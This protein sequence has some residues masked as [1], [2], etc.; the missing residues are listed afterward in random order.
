MAEFKPIKVV[1]QMFRED[2]NQKS[3][4]W[5]PEEIHFEGKLIVESL[6]GFEP[7]GHNIHFALYLTKDNRYTLVDVYRQWIDYRV[8]CRFFDSLEDI[9][10]NYDF[11]CFIT[12]G[13]RNYAE[14]HYEWGYYRFIEEANSKGIPLPHWNR[15]YYR[16]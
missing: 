11:S 12:P 6:S 9:T 8:D 2:Q 13:L 15:R 4:A 5:P 3:Y 7:A 10:P 16:T 14:T 1:K